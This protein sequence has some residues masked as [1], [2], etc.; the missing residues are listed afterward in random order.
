MREAVVEIGPGEGVLTEE[1][2]RLGKP[3]FVIEKDIKLQGSLQKF[4]E[5]GVEIVWSDVLMVDFEAFAR[6]RFLDLSK[7]LVV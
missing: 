6:E 5:Q 2:L 3:L 1:L 4:V 7:V